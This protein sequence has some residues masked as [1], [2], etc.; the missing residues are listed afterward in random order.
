[1]TCIIGINCWITFFEM[2]R[3]EYIWVNRTNIEHTS[4][5]RPKLFD[6][7]ST[8]I[9]LDRK[10]LMPYC[11]S[12]DSVYCCIQWWHNMSQKPWS[13]L[14]KQF[15]P[16]CHWH[17][18]S[19]CHPCIPSRLDRKIPIVHHQIRLIVAFISDD[20]ICHRS[21]KV[22]SS[23]SYSGI[24]IGASCPHPCHRCV[25]ALLSSQCC[26]TVSRSHSTRSC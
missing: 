1:M 21:H 19:S 18:V 23:H 13:A 6:V 5:G 17:V 10:S 15:W 9:L 12:S 24:V 25:V 26:Y 2:K 14:I 16:S 4:N 11:A 7:H 20:I 22:G 8:I 3:N